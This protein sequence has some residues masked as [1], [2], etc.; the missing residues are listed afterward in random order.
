MNELIHESLGY[1]YAAVASA[2]TGA[3]FLTLTDHQ[4][5]LHGINDK[6]FITNL[7][8]QGIM[9]FMTGIQYYFIKELIFLLSVTKVGPELGRFLFRNDKNPDSD[10][11][12]FWGR[13]F[14]G[15]GMCVLS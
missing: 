6:S 8:Q 12:R 14:A 15:L 3:F 1:K 7:S 13:F 4:M 9:K 5:Y 2:L 11:A 10:R